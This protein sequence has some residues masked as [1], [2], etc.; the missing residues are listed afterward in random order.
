MLTQKTYTT[1]LKQ[2]KR[3]KNK[4]AKNNLSELLSNALIWTKAPVAHTSQLK[5]TAG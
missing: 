2:K 5:G 1:I 4:A 3:K